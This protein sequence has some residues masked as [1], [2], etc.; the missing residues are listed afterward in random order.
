M[1]IIHSIP[2]ATRYQQRAQCRATKTICLDK[3]GYCLWLSWREILWAIQINKSRRWRR[4]L[5]NRY[6]PGFPIPP[7]DLIRQPLI[8]TQ[9]SCINK[10]FVHLPFG[11]KYLKLARITTFKISYKHNSLWTLL[12]LVFWDIYCQMGV[13]ITCLLTL[14]NKE[15]FIVF[16]LSDMNRVIK[17]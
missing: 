10:I 14:F 7:I 4:K 17:S 5:Q 13:G 3:D 6:E 1:A 8:E 9:S 11:K 15:L 12:F 2:N 16:C